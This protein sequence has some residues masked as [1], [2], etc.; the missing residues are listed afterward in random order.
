LDPEVYTNPPP[1]LMD[2]DFTASDTEA[3]DTNR[4][5]RDVVPV[6]PPQKETP[7]YTIT[8]RTIDRTMSAATPGAA[9]IANVLYTLIKDLKALKLGINLDV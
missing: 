9:E 8:N 4:G 1:P 7:S 5:G 2:R 3:T 6:V